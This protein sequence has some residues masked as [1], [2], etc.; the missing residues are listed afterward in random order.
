MHKTPVLL[1]QLGRLCSPKRLLPVV[2]SV[3]LLQSGAIAQQ[4][5]GADLNVVRLSPQIRELPLGTTALSI[6]R[7]TIEKFLTGN[8][9]IAADIY[10]TAPYIAAST[11][12]N[13]VI[14]A[15][16]EVYLRGDFNTALLNYDLFRPGD[17]YKDPETGEIL[18]LEAVYLGAIQIHPPV[19]EDMRT[20]LIRSTR[21]ELKAGDRLLPRSNENLQHTFSPTTPEES[22]DGR[23][24]GI[25]AEKSMAAQYD[26]VVI[27]R[28]EREGLRVGDLLGIFEAD[29]A[30]RDSIS[31]DR[32]SLPGNQVAEVMIYRTFEKLSYGLILN[33]TRPTSPGFAARSL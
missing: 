8:R 18:G 29:V 31:G 7:A 19:A 6:P 11:T 21:R 3:M 30:M 16:D 27:N 5:P 20:G 26:A 4:N 22:I 32:I 23:I 33:S 13:L 17:T 25:L 15:G 24:I 10:E 28:G 9:I 2:A 1:R 14:G 12:G